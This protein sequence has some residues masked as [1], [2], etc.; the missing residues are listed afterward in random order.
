MNIPISISKPILVSG[1]YFKVEYST[2]GI[3]WVFDSYQT[4]NVFMTATNTFV[5]G[6]TYYF[7]FS[8]VKSMSPYVECDA[9]MRI[10]TIPNNADCIED[11]DVTMEEIATNNY[12]IKVA[13]NYPIS[14][15]M[16][17][18]GFVF[19]YGQ[20]YPLTAI[21][22]AA[23]PTSPFYI[24]V[25]LGTYFYDLYVVDCNGRETLCK[26][27]TTNYQRPPCTPATV[28]NAALTKQG[29]TR[30]LQFQL[31]HSI[32]ASST[33]TLSYLQTNNNLNGNIPDSGTLTIFATP[34]SSQT[35]T[36]VINP[37]YNVTN[38]VGIFYQFTITDG[39]GNT[40][41]NNLSKD[42]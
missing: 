8:I 28:S 2:D 35:V 23:L 37:N 21:Q 25:S 18:G 39:C 3:N 7:K 6:N 40:I 9:V 38:Y 36:I 22:Y 42:F 16:P 19:K 31:T 17:C 4:N 14:Y 13:Y 15:N 30:Y 1:E 32:P 34:S 33:Y 11:F 41:V 5:A 20:T 10:Y 12:R 29:N 27:G 26:M 24:P